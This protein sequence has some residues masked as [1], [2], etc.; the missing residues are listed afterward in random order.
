MVTLIDK[1]DVETINEICEERRNRPDELLEILHEIQSRTGFI[2]TDAMRVVA[3]RLNISQA[4]VYGVVTF[5]HDFR[6]EAPGRVVVRI[7]RAEACQAVG[8]ETLAEHAEDRLGVKFG[9]NSASG[10]YSLDAVYC[11]GNC[12]LGPAVMING[13]LFGR[14]TSERFDSLILQRPPV[15]ASEP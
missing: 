2:S 7:C 9:A 6:R 13:A 10:D 14:V 1:T 4:E 8:S 11:L 3:D 5:Y 12:A 15:D